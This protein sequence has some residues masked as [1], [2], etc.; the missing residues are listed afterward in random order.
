MYHGIIS[1]ILASVAMVPLHLRQSNRR[2]AHIHHGL[3]MVT[4]AHTHHGICMVTS[5]TAEPATHGPWPLPQPIQQRR[6]RLYAVSCPSTAPMEGSRSLAAPTRV[7]PSRPQSLRFQTESLGG[8]RERFHRERPTLNGLA[9]RIALATNRA[10]C[11]AVQNCLC[12]AF[13]VYNWHSQIDAPPKLP[14]WQGLRHSPCRSHIRVSSG[15]LGRISVGPR[16]SYDTALHAVLSNSGCLS[17]LQGRC[18]GVPHH[19]ARPRK[20]HILSSS[21][22]PTHRA[23]RVIVQRTGPCSRPCCPI[24][25]SG[26]RPPRWYGGG[27]GRHRRGTC[28]AQ[29]GWSPSRPDVAPP[30]R[31][32]ST[33]ST[34]LAPTT[35]PWFPRG[36]G[37][38]QSSTGYHPSQTEP[39]RYRAHRAIVQCSPHET[40]ACHA[41][42]RAPA[43]RQPPT[44]DAVRT[45]TVQ[46]TQPTPHHCRHPHPRRT[47]ARR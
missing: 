3:C 37:E 25:D 9:A 41:Q 45:S 16:R 35:R 10:F 13:Q 33:V 39:C 43:G 21:S 17:L 20:N 38:R 22:C 12:T 47:A 24:H 44:I 27:H 23:L 6:L 2:D 11:L 36:V 28:M 31:I 4:S 30:H 8:E 34:G 42:G 19:H 29:C 5:A 14:Q 7:A 26:W 1:C 18:A 32:P 15:R 40:E 46:S